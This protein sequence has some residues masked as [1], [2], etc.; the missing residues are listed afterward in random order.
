M[1]GFNYYR[2]GIAK[3]LKLSNLKYDSADL[4]KLNE[5]LLQRVNQTKA[6]VIHQKKI[7]NSNQEMFNQAAQNYQDLE[8]RFSFI[9]YNQTS[10][11]S[12]IWGWLGNYLGFSGY[13]N[14]FTGEAQVNTTGPKTLQ[15]FVTSHEIAHQLGYAGEME[16]NFV[17]Y[18]AAIQSKDTS[19]QYSAYLDIFLY[20]NQN[21]FRFDSSAA[22][23][24][25][26][27]LSPAVQNDLTEIIK[28]NQ[29]HQSFLEPVFNTVFDLFLKSQ[30][31]KQGVLGYNEVVGLVIGYE[32]KSKK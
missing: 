32:L 1:W 14:P 27:Q 9:N 3:Q 19:F 12:S 30:H 26:K 2:Q 25:R 22:K 15:P 16:A 11:K 31:Q 10:I 18:L 23:K 21:Y 29:A 28:F 24:I 20:A 7:I 4:R 13:Y 8:Q 17:G 6:I 5:T